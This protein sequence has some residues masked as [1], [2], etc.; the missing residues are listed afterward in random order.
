MA[1]SRFVRFEDLSFEEPLKRRYRQFRARKG[2]GWAALRDLFL[3]I[4]VLTGV[5]LALGVV[6]LTLSAILVVAPF[7]MVVS[8]ILKK[9][10][11]QPVI[12]RTYRPS[13]SETIIDLE[14]DRS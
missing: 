14:V 4:L 6:I 10:T 7:F 11:P 1:D 2:F 3:L 5:G 13:A 8:A 12:Q 9:F